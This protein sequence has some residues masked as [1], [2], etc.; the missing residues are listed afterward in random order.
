MS[1]SVQG[2]YQIAYKGKYG[3]RTATVRLHD[4]V[5]SGMDTGG[6]IW[7]GNYRSSGENVHVEMAVTNPGLDGQTSVLDGYEGE[8][9]RQITFE[10][11]RSL[12]GVKQLDIATNHGSLQVFL[13]RLE[14]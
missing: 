7:K 12:H 13:E 6:G 2:T 5:I 8:G 9:I 14:D 10:L 3:S 4:G 1:K 11:P